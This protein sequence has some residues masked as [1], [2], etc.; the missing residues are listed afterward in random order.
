MGVR[1]T[2]EA[3]PGDDRVGKRG[4]RGPSGD[5]GPGVSRGESAAVGLTLAPVDS[6]PR[7]F[8]G[9]ERDGEA[10]PDEGALVTRVER[11][12]AADRAGVSPGDVIVQVNGQRVA[13]PQSAAK[14]LEAVRPG[15]FV[16]MLVARGPART[17]LAFRR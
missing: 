17:F 11:G 14:A 2:L 5:D 9:R 6:V 16:R 4:E 10:V 1:L 12:S 8:R 15:D 13:D 3:M 7:G